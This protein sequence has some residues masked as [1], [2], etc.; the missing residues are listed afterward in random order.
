METCN[1]NL[2]QAETLYRQKVAQ[3]PQDYELK[4]GLVRVLLAEQKVD[5]AESTVKAAL[6]MAPQSVEL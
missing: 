1:G 2:Q 3:Q 4:A 5:E 6:G